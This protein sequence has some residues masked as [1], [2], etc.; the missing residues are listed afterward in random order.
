MENVII[1][2]LSVSP[3]HLFAT[4]ED[5]WDN[6]ENDKTLFTNET[7]IPKIMVLAGVV[8]S[9]S[10]VRRNRQDLSRNIEENSFEIIKWGKK[11]LFI[12]CGEQGD[13]IG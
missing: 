6:N 1:G 13:D 9:A 7:F 2:R 5:D 10:E 12:A 11:F 8:K 4:S 3:H